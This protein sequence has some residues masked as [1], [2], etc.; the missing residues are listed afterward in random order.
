M[1]HRYGDRQGNSRI[2]R[3]YKE[4][5]PKLRDRF[6]IYPKLQSIETINFFSDTIRIYS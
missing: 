6:N 5:M 4:R 1:S 2:N 3:C